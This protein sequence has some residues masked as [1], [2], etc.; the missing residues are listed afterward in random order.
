[1]L[2]VIEPDG[3]DLPRRGRGR[4]QVSRCERGRASQ[5]DI[6][7]PGGELLPSLVNRLRVGGEPALA[8]PLDVERRGAI[9][10]NEHQ[11]AGKVGNAHSMIPF[12]FRS[13]E[14]SDDLLDAAI[15]M[16]I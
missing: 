16:V 12:A 9:V 8:G 4:A 11:P 15:T 10:R 13:H 5:V 2:G 6:R 3:K 14:R 7:R 1:V